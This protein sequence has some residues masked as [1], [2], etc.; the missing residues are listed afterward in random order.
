MKR[1]NQWRP[2]DKTRGSYA[3]YQR[4][5]LKNTD[6][7]TPEEG[8]SISRHYNRW[9]KYWSRG[10]YNARRE[11]DYKLEK[12]LIIKYIDK[13]FEDFLKAWHDRTRLLRNQGVVLDFSY[14]KPE[15]TDQPDK[16]NQYYVD[17]DGIIRVNSG[18]NCWSHGKNP[19]KIVEKEIIRYRIKSEIYN[20]D[21]W[22]TPF[23][24][25]M[26]IL[27]RYLSTSDYRA[28]V[29]GSISSET[30][31]RLVNSSMYSG[32]NWT[33][34][35]FAHKHNQKL[36]ESNPYAYRNNPDWCD[37]NCFKDLFDA[38]YS[39]SIYRYIYPGTPEF[40]RY[41]AERRDAER[42]NRRE[43]L[44]QKEEYTASLLHNIEAD[45]KAREAELNN[46]KII[47]HGFD[48]KESF[49]GEEYHGQKRK[50]RNGDNWAI[51]A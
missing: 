30:F 51:D 17:M 26:Q 2:H 1:D 4:Q 46:Q 10:R 36:L 45:R 19:I 18:Y 43:Y 3:P 40:A 23:A 38:D 14:I 8:E 32:I 24:G 9:R 34:D 48:D 49:R 33:I 28:I 47:K 39:G 16:W 29:A 41:E 15:M 13:P 31:E 42:K 50:K 12:N 44:K 25:I 6:W 21:W 22:T 27:R 35:K 37:Y 7:V 20:S 5:R 11:P